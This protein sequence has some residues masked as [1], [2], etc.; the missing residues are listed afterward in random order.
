MKAVRAD[1]K[2]R[3]LEIVHYLS[4]VRFVDEH[5]TQVT[6]R[7]SAGRTMEIDLTTRHVLKASVYLH[8]YNLVESTMNA[9]MA[10]AAAEIG[11]SG[12]VYSDLTEHWQKSWLQEFGQTTQPL[13]PE[14]RLKSLLRLCDKLLSGSALEFKPSLNSGNLDD[15]RIQD[16]LQRHGIHIQ[17]PRPL[18]TRLKRHVQDQDGP[19]VVIRKRRNDLAHG[20]TSFGECGRDVSTTELR[21]WTFVVIAYLRH[22]VT[23]FEHFVNAHGFR[24]KTG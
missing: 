7:S 2:Q 12:A 23:Y 19:L 9:C 14:N 17:F 6:S 8:L 4:L 18:V 3:C 21:E 22:I 20:L 10:R 5:G 24:R 11:R 13:N 16:E 1:F 15:L